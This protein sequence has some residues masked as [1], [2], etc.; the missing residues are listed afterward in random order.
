MRKYLPRPT[1]HQVNPAGL[2]QHLINHLLGLPCQGFSPGGVKIPYDKGL[3]GHSD[4]DVLLHAICDALLGA[5]ALGDIGAHFPDTDPSY[6]GIAC[7]ALAAL[8]SISLGKT[9]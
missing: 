1:S 4:A 2:L 6:K 7:L 5:C 8:R 3:E 9:L